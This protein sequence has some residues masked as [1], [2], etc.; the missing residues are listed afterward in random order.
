MVQ[1]FDIADEQIALA[2]LGREVTVTVIMSRIGAIS[3]SREGISRVQ[4]STARI[5]ILAKLAI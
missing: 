3:T 4:W 5:A 1:M 2:V